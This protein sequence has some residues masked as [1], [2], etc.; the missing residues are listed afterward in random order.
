MGDTK[1][2]VVRGKGA[3]HWVFKP[4]SLPAAQSACRQTRQPGA[5]TRSPLH[6]QLLTDHASWLC[7]WSNILTAK[8]ATI[9]YQLY[10]TES[11]YVSVVKQFALDFAK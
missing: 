10:I 2:L 3:A 8:S 6:N 9:V 11:L 1:E 7:F 5:E 4:R